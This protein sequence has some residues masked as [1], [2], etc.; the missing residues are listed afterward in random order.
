MGGVYQNS[1]DRVFD[2]QVDES[3]CNKIRFSA[4]GDTILALPASYYTLSS[5]N[6]I[7]IMK[8]KLNGGIEVQ[9]T[10]AFFNDPLAIKNKYVV[11][12]RLLG[13]NDVDTILSGKSGNPTPDPRVASDWDIVPKNFTMFAVK[14][15]NEYHGTYFYY[16]ASSVKDA[17]NAVIETTTYSATYVENNPVASLVTTGR[18][19]VSLT[20]NLHSAVLTG[21]VTMLL[22]FS[23]NTCTIVGA[24]GSTYTI[25][26]TGEFKSKAYTWGN[27]QR[28][29]IVL[30]LTVT[31]G[32][33]TYTANDVM[34]IRDRAVVMEIY[35]PKTY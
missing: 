8:G 13:S 5:P 18:N 16:G 33:N 29:G 6:K 2:I 17:T 22:N 15:I 14:Y 7:T 1:I 24:P 27:K 12:I 21:S 32:V 11:P 19:Q 23:G 35:D 10:D 31:N 4:T 20:T 26:G 25:S 9:L 30:N 28:D 34:V 3:L